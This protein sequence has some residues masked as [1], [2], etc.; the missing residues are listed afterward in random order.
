MS[1]SAFI[2]FVEGS[3]VQSLSLTELQEQLQHYRH[4]LGLTGKQLDWNY[5]DAGFPYTIESK[6]EGK[7]KWFYLQGTYVKYNHIVLG[8]GMELKGEAEQH[9]IQAVLPD[10]A[11]YGDK[12][13]AN[14]LCKYLGKQFQAELQLFNGRTMYYNPR[15]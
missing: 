1:Q 8:V 3:T 15:K 7:D 4:Q 5:S 6:P 12:A 14:E 9:Y 13:K 10:D 11:T 2:K